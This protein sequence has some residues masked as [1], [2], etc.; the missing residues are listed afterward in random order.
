M[1]LTKYGPSIS[2]TDLDFQNQGNFSFFRP[3]V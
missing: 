2:R 1:D 3:E